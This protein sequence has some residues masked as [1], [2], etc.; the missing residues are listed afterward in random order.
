MK[1]LLVLVFVFVIFWLW[2]N[3]RRIEK[4]QADDARRPQQPSQSNALTEIVACDVCQVHLPR[5]E[6][7]IGNKGVYCSDAHRRQA[8]R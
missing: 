2:S 8:D 7:L 4:K 5:S 3:N 6:A 1:Y